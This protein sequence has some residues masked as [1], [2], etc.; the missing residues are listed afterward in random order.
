MT[1]AERRAA[2]SLARYRPVGHRGAVRRIGELT[3]LADCYNANPESFR[4]AI[5]QCRDLYPGRR[6]AAFIGSM[7]ELGAREAE[8]HSAVAREISGAGFDV[9]AATG[10]FEEADFPEAGPDADAPT[11]VRGPDVDATCKPVRRHFGNDLEPL[12]VDDGD[13]LL[14]T[15]SNPDLA[16]VGCD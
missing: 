16:A 8:A 13:R 11:V 5:A 14:L 3:V 9:I 15:V 7:L 10:A 1:P 6:L 2:T 12:G 4:A